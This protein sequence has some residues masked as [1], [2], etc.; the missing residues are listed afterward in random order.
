MDNCHG[1]LAKR[2]G[3]IGRA[4]HRAGRIGA[5]PCCRLADFGYG[6]PP[7][8]YCH[9]ETSPAMD[10]RL[11][12]VLLPVIAASL[13]FGCS[14]PPPRIGRDLPKGAG[15]A[16]YFNDRVV[17]R[18]PVGSD[19]NKLVTELKNERFEITETPDPTSRYRFSAA[20]QVNSIVCRE[21]W[22]I[23]WNSEQGVIK[24]IHA[25]SRAICL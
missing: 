1:S 7:C 10:N 2:R 4:H 16:Q 18:F 5:Q 9:R 17:Q 6:S 19:Q 25:D 24:E 3:P 22:T 8:D 13:L 21:A 14:R 15:Y 20:Y 12:L 23:R 11:A